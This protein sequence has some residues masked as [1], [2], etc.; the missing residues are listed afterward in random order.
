MKLTIAARPENRVDLEGFTGERRI[1]VGDHEVP[2]RNNNM[3]R[4]L[5]HIVGAASLL[6]L[7]VVISFTPISYAQEGAKGGGQKLME[8]KPLK[9][10]S[11]IQKLKTG[12]LVVEVCPK[13]KMMSYT[14]IAKTAKGGELVGAKSSSRCPGCGADLSA[15]DAKHTCKMCGSEMVCCIIPSAKQYDSEK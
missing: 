8:A 1:I 2:R 15:V 10:S 11:D 13:C 9:S 5:N 7:A 6:S 12:D 4:I 3:K 14:R